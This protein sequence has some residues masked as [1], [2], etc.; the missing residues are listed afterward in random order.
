MYSFLYR[1]PKNLLI[2][3]MILFLFKIT[4]SRVNSY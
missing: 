4:I 2:H 1:I 3:C